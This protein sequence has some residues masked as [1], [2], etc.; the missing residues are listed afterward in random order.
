MRPLSSWLSSL[1]GR[2]ML[3]FCLLALLLLLLVTLGNLSLYWVKGAD[4]FLYEKALPASEAARQLSQSATSLAENAQRL[5]TVADEKQRQ[6]LGRRLS[7]ESNRMLA[8]IATLEQLAVPDSANLKQAAATIIAELTLL[9]EQTGERLE[10]TQ[11]LKQK[12]L[13]LVQASKQADNLLRSELAVLDSVI[14]AKLS[15]IPGAAA[16]DDIIELDLSSAEQLNRALKLTHKIALL[17]QIFAAAD[18]PQDL[19]GAINQAPLTDDALSPGLLKRIPVADLVRDPGRAEALEAEFARL[20]QVTAGQ[21]L[22]ESIWQ[23]QQ[24]LEQ[25][26]LVISDNLK[27]MEQTVDAALEGQQQQLSLARRDFLGQL[28]WASAGL[29]G[30]GALML[31]LILF[32]SWQVIYKGIARRLSDATQALSRLSLGDTDVS[33]RSYG[34]DELTAMAS[35]LEA[36]KQKTAH[37]QKL[38]QDLQR[39]AAELT[40][41]KLALELKVAERTRELAQ[42]N[43]QLE[44][45]SQAKSLFL[46]TM[47]HEIRT[48]LNGLLGTLSLLG[49]AEL[50]AKARQMLALS[51]YSGTQL[52]TVL[53]DILDFSRLEQGRLLN[54]PRAVELPALLNEVTAIMLAG[55]NLAGLELRLLKPKL[56]EWVWLDG[57]K[58]RQVLFNL[59]GNAIKFT[60]KGSVTLEVSIE[61]ARLC[62][63][64]TDTGIGIRP[65]AMAH[66]F[67]PYATEATHA[68]ARGTGLGLSISRDLV[69]LMNGCE[70][71]DAPAIEVISTPGQG[72]RFSFSVPLQP[73]EQGEQQSSSLPQSEIAK[74]VLLVEDNRVNALVAQGFLAHLGHESLLCV[75]LAEARNVLLDNTSGPFDAVMLDLQLSDGSGSELLPELRQQLGPKVPIAAFT[76][77][78]QTQDMADY[79]AM[80]FDIVLGKP[81]GLQA[82]ANWLGVVSGSNQSDERHKEEDTQALGLK[83]LNTDNTQWLALEQLEQDLQVLGKATLLEMRQQFVDSCDAQLQALQ[84]ADGQRDIQA[85]KL[86][87]LKGSSGNM[88]LEA[89][90]LRCAALEQAIK[91]GKP[92]RDEELTELTDCVAASLQALDNWLEQQS[93]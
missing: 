1:T 22:A 58:L 54:E 71:G 63:S 6:Y 48:P 49:Q 91:T 51:Q 88:G 45:A 81:L 40:E 33:I 18:A 35:A 57:P 34:D 14:I 4:S 28:N 86:H 46:A 92:L 70:S 56:P 23:L 78:L 44:E 12:G 87:A 39:T 19:V 77:Q 62:F 27:S 52:Q 74:R 24:Q 69:Q 16:V 9:G 67:T 5:G 43:A 60:A 31:L 68:S 37:N 36:F 66:L 47:S 75:S 11:A 41:H 29:W 26:Q 15:Q 50:P 79:Q 93:D 64:V 3:A 53:N 32:V 84:A 59:L 30:T 55:A 17:G 2:L 7:L 73:C 42:T 65:E 38:Q 90:H 25:R 76:A 61:D 10:R 72:S 83:S 89:L 80:G 82:L 85:A 20:D 13:L 8:A 21:Q